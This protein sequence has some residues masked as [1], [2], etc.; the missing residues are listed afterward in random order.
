MTCALKGA[1]LS[2]RSPHWP[3]ESAHGKQCCR[4]SAL[5]S[6]AP[7][8][9]AASKTGKKDYSLEEPGQPVSPLVQIP[10]IFGS[11]FPFENKTLPKVER[12]RARAALHAFRFV[13]KHVMHYPD[14]SLINIH[15]SFSA[16]SSWS[17]CST[18]FSN[19]SPWP[20]K[21]DRK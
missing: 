9:G 4:C 14:Y 2:P 3:V 19:P 13:F 1:V 21:N 12:G 11:K 17:S 5:P 18:L 16:K 15:G 7:S 6:S 10:F 8:C 20:W